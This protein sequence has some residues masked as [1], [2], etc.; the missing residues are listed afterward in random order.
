MTCPRLTDASACLAHR[1]T[2]WHHHPGNW[3]PIPCES[4]R[5][6]RARAEAAAALVEAEE[7][8]ARTCPSCGA[9]LRY[10]D[11]ICRPCYTRAK[12]KKCRCGARI[13][14]KATLCRPC[15]DAE[16]RGPRSAE[17]DAQITA[18]CRGGKG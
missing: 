6:G 12:G 18:E 9:V 11:G 10:A 13:T 4:C 14:N 8:A 7:L 17:W 15:A 2:A 16:R 5:V 3:H 1:E